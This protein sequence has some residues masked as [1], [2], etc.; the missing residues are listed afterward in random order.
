MTS[1]VQSELISE[2]PKVALAILHQDGKF[3][4]QLRDDNPDILYPGHW[5]FL[6]DI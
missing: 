2:M 3:L 5:G 6:A 1:D 4:M